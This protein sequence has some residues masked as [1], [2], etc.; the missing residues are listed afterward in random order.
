VAFGE[1][2]ILRVTALSLALLIGIGALI[3]LTTH[4]SQASA[5]LST[6]LKKKNR[7]HK[8]FSKK[9]WR[10]YRSRIRKKKALESRRR[11]QRLRRIRLANAA[12]I[13]AQTINQKT[14]GAVP[15]ILVNDLFILAEGKVKDVFDGETFSFETKDGKFYLVR[16]LGV[17]APEINRDFGD[18]SQKKLSDLILGRNATV[19]IRKRDSAGRYLGTV[20]SGGEDINLLQIETGMAWFFRQTGYEPVGVDRKL[21]EQ[22][23][24]KA[25]SKRTGLWGRQKLNNTLALKR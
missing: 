7:K 14:S 2:M 24:Q 15:A 12:K 17:D 18:K 13:P 11:I 5:P 22:A 10:E 1:N 8:K 6:K 19:I 23:E 25:R 4:F 16:M 21:Y 9:W 20:Y 3:P